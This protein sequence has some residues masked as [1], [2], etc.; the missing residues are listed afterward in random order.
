MMASIQEGQARLPVNVAGL[1]VPEIGL[2]VAAKTPAKVAKKP[3]KKAASAPS[4]E[5]KEK[6]KTPPAAKKVVS[7]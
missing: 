6:V 1:G 5:A 3:A 4:A 2:K 7:D